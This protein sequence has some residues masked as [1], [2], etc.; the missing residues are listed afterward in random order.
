MEIKKRRPKKIGNE[1][2]KENI[3]N[4]GSLGYRAVLSLFQLTCFS[5]AGYMVYVQLKTYFSNQDLS[6]VAYENFENGRQDIFPT[7]S[8]CAVGGLWILKANKLPKNHITREYAE[9]LSGQLHDQMNYSSIQFDRVVIDVNKL[10]SDFC[11]TTDTGAKIIRTVF[12]I[13]GARNSNSSLRISHFDSERICVTKEDFQE[14]S[15]VEKDFIGLTM[16]GWEGSRLRNGNLDLDFYIHQKGQLLRSLKRP[17][18]HFDGRYLSK[19]LENAR[20]KRSSMKMETTIKFVH[21]ISDLY[22]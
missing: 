20:K 5:L 22:R 1:S 19:A 8:V 9:I 7:F 3:R 10:I 2:R 6:T 13:C 21:I 17:S 14:T 4:R 12:S 11:T 15:L 16:Q 18:Y